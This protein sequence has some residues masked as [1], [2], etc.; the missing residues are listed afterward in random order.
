MPSFPSQKQQ[1]EKNPTQ[2]LPAAQRGYMFPYLYGE[3]ERE[4]ERER[5][6]E[7]QFWSLL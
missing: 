5:L 4:R 6:I 1:E 3:R 7:T 2:Q